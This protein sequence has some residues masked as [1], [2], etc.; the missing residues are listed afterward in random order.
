MT[1]VLFVVFFYSALY[2]A[3]FFFG[4]AILTIQFFVDK[5]SLMRLWGW[6]PLI[7]SELAVFSRKYFFTTALIALAL[8]S[9]YTWAQFPYDN[10][11]DSPGDT[12]GFSGNYTGVS[13][14]RGKLVGGDGSVEVKQDTSVMYC[15]Q[16]WRWVF[17]CYFGASMVIVL[18]LSC[19]LVISEAIGIS[20]PR[21]PRVAFENGAWRAWVEE[22]KFPWMTSSQVS[23]TYCT[24]C[25]LFDSPVW[26]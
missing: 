20:L 1:K 21:L 22:Y 4:A 9:S 5:F 24:S 7:G 14:L 12:A 13:T 11:C 17:C 8:V 15:S 3:G 23:R 10:I 18:I 2:P 25:F 19:S 16:S 6:S 26:R